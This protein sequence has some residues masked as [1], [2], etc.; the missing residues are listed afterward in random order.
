[1]AVG[2]FASRMG[3]SMGRNADAY[4]FT[5]ISTQVTGLIFCERGNRLMVLMGARDRS[6]SHSRS[7]CH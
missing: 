3:L 1:M 2:L 4:I 7:R 6:R 5:I